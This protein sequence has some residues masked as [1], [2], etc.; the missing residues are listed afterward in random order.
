MIL[1]PK[2][3]SVYENLNTSFTQFD[4]LLS[5]LKTSQFTG[6]VR[7][8]AWEYE[9]LVLMDQGNSVS[10]IEETPG[11]KRVGIAAAEAIA[12]KAKEKDG[13]IH[14]AG[15]DSDLVALLGGLAQGEPLYKDLA[16]D[17]THLDKL[18]AKL[19]DE[20]HSG[21]IEIRFTGS[22]DTATVYL[23]EGVLVECVLMN[24]GAIVSGADQLAQITEMATQRPALFT[25][26]R[27]DLAS[28]YSHHADL[29]SSFA[30][31]ATFALWQHV[32][33]TI[34]RVVDADGATE[35]FRT[36]FKRACIEQA[37]AYPFLDP[38]AGEF[39]YRAGQITFTGAVSVNEFNQ[40]L[41][42]GFA[43][44]VRKLMTAGDA[45][46]IPGLSAAFADLK[47]QSNQ[48]LEEIGL[49]SAAPELFSA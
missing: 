5:E 44:A 41:C 13:A 34:E 17:F 47:T 32:F 27:S 48:R 49:L 12:L 46:W 23:Q 1:L 39:D 20:A 21:Y 33:Q 38:F 35:H 4:A 14:V 37:T 31:Q 25:V 9:G 28:I 19:Q 18:V 10:A 24:G 40:G 29:A 8:A 15:L 42:A 26:Y 22:P 11:A 6:Y 30:R 2:G 7:V 45:N 36:A 43:S 16:S 3:K